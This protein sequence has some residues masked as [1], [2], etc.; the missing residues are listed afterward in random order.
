MIARHN[1]YIYVLIFLFEANLK[2]LIHSRRILGR[3]E[4]FLKRYLRVLDVS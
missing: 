2:N 4:K 3:E 1:E